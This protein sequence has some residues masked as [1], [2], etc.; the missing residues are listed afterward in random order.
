RSHFCH[1][2]RQPGRRQIGKHDGR[3]VGIACRPHL[4]HRLQVLFKGRVG[5]D[6]FFDRHRGAAPVRPRGHGAT[7]RVRQPHVRSFARST[8]RPPH[9]IPPYHSLT[10]PLP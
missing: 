9:F 2:G 10:A 8:P 6:F 3:V 7:H 1:G 5:Q 4:Q